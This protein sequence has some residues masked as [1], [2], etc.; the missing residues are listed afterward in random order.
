MEES[1]ASSFTASQRSVLVTGCSSGIGRA[2]ALGLAR[3]GYTVFAT[4]RT[5]AHATEL[6]GLGIPDLVPLCPLDLTHLEHIPPVMARVEAELAQRGQAGLYAVVHNAGG[7]SVAPIELLNLEHFRRELETRLLG[8]V[9]L[10]QACLPLIRSAHGRLVWIVTPAIIP[11]PYVASIH[12]CDFAVN[13]I[14]RTLEI[15]LKPWDIPNIMI[16][17]GGIK[18]AAGLRTTGEVAALFAAAPPERLELYRP[19][20]S[21]WGEDMAA[22]DEKRAEPAAV[23]ALVLK[24][25]EARHP[26]RRYSIGHMAGMAAVLEALP[27]PLADAVLKLRF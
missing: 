1:F 7:S 8:S 11:T 4:V 20:L 5:E 6:R 14:A 21:R 18:T 2:T 16:R 15:E 10:T 26:R 13:C 25:L 9:A 17:C 24:A 19:T 3:A 12:A 23:A 27:Q 22:F